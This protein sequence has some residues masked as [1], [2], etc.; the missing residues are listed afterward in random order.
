M[1]D[2]ARRALPHVISDGGPGEIRL[3]AR[4]LLRYPKTLRTYLLRLAV[5][6]AA[7]TTRDLATTHVDSL[8]SLVRSGSGK[9]VDLPGGLRAR[10]ERDRIVLRLGNSEQTVEGRHPKLESGRT[11]ADQDQEVSAS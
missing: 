5:Q 2:R 10:K 9:S 1:E 3:D 4:A 8:H 11:S 7:G 6:E